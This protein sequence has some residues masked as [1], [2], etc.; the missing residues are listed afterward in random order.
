[1]ETTPAEETPTPPPAEDPPKPEPT[2]LIDPEPEPDID[3]RVRSYARM[4]DPDV[5]PP[6]GV[7]ARSALAL[8]ARRRQSI[9]AAQACIVLADIER[10]A[11]DLAMR[12]IEARRL[13]LLKRIYYA[14]RG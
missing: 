9:M 8:Q 13:P 10:Q 11:Y 14:I 4:I 7:Q 3:P 6:A 1:M 12:D 5:W 2:K